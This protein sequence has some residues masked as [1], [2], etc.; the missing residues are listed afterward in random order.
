MCGIAGAIA[1]NTS[2]NIKEAIIVEMCDSIKHRGP[3][4][5]G[6]AQSAHFNS[7]NKEFQQN[8]K[9]ERAFQLG[10]RRLSIIDLSTSAGQPMIDQSGKYILVFNGEIYNHQKLRKDL[11]KEGVKFK[12]SH[13][14][15]EVLLNGLIHEGKSFLQKLNGMFSFC[16]M[17]LENDYTL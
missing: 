4:G 16:F 12:T 6:Y 7:L 15:T 1:L 3:D 11:E 5:E 17:D 14:D 2:S 13:S 9:H 8:F 10:H